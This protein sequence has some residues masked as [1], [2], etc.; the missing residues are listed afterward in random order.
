M[1]EAIATFEDFC[2]LNKKDIRTM[3]EDFAQRTQADRRIVFGLSHT[4]QFQGLMHW[5][6]DY[7]RCLEIPVAAE[8]TLLSVA[9]VLEQA[10]ARELRNNQ[11]STLTKAANPGKLKEK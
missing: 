5:V 10:S 7:F 6:Q 4:K 1:G 3:A 9:E 8:C 2:G 11:V